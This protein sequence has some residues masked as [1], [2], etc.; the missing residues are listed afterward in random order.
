MIDEIKKK[1]AQTRK[2]TKERRKQMSIKV[3]EAKIQTDKLSKEKLENLER[4]FLEAKWLANDIIS[5]GPFTYDT[6]Q[7][8]V[9]VKWIKDGV[10][11]SKIENLILPGHVKLKLKDQ[12]KQDIFTLSKK[13][14]KGGKVGRLK[15]KR[16]VNSITFCKYGYGDDW[17]FSKKS[18]FKIYLMGIGHL[19]VNGLKQK[20]LANV[21]E[22]GPAKLI[23]KPS[24][25]YIQMTGFLDPIIPKQIPKEISKDRV[26]GI[27]MGIKDTIVMSNGIKENFKFKKELR[28]LARL[29]RRI[30]K[31][32][33]GSNNRKK[34]IKKF[35]LANERL[36]NKK[37][38]TA[39]LFVSKL[40]KNFDIIAIQDE[41]LRGWQGGWFGKQIM[42]S[43]LGRIKSEL[44]KYPNVIVINRFL[45]TTKGCPDCGSHFSVKLDERIFKCP[46]CGFEEDRDTKSAKCIA[47]YG[48][49]D[50]PTEYR[51]V[52]LVDIKTASFKECYH[53]FDT[54]DVTKSTMAETRN[55]NELLLGVSLE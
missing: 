55:S 7:K 34:A 12:I 37:V 51:E 19:K 32:V 24:G 18:I 42:E 35:R 50:L 14:K 53:S 36:V 21:R 46:D 31:K 10:E 22:W 47:V 9:E 3:F 8:N 6:K 44:K 38:E 20:E 39:R 45:P 25:Y 48:L 27:D 17:Y 41:N 26:I 30:S 54:F 2:Q 40:K 23:R 43:C 49:L 52:T 28:R 11:F 33:K 4:F 15:F 13:K 16:E 1:I 5:K 29:S